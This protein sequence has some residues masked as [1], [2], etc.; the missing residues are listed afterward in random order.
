MS[1]G[2]TD[3]A[4]GLQAYLFGKRGKLPD[5]KPMKPLLTRL[6]EAGSTGLA[7]SPG[8]SRLCAE[9]ATEI[10]RLQKIV[11]RLQKIVNTWLVKQEKIDGED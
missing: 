6:D 11:N 1:D 5:K 3:S 9:A 4:N 10:R 2:I 7:L 8:D